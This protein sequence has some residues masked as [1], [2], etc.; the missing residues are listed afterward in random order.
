MAKPK[1]PVMGGTQRDW[2]KHW[3]HW[4]H[5]LWAG[6][7]QAVQGLLW[8]VAAG[9]LLCTLNTVVR[10][11]TL[12]LNVYQSLFLRYLFGL[13]VI[14]PL[15]RR[16][17]GEFVPNNIMGQ[18]WRGGVH[19]VGLMLWF[20]A[21]PHIGLADMTAL[22]FTG[23]IFV[24]LGAAWF[25]GERMR[26]DRWAAAVLGFSGVLIIVAPKLGGSDGVYTLIMLSSSPMFAASFL[27]TKALTQSE[28]PSVIVLWQ[29]L[30]VSLFALPMALYFWQAPTAWQW[31][32]FF[33]AGLFGS[34]G[35]FCMTQAFKMT[36]ISATQSLRFLDLIWASILGWLVFSDLPSPSTLL[37]AMVI[38]FSTLWIARRESRRARLPKASHD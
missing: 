37:G 9:L 16:G 25:L 28:K 2:D 4:R 19:T 1:M 35:H 3:R 24:M 15:L 38:A 27:I 8:A 10:S 32:G 18:F 12:N 36:D 22:G 21:L 17:W 6:Q 20:T 14:L 29:S 11:I 31:L 13:V 5:R 30:T 23:P 33:V 34:L 7:T 26:L